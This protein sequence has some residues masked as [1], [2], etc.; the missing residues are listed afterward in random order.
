MNRIYTKNEWFKDKNNRTVI[1]RGVNL[2]GDCKNPYPDGG[3]YIQTDFSNH[4]DVSFV[5]R[6]FPLKDADEHFTRLKSW[7]FN[8]LR[9]L[10][11]WEAIEHSGP[12]K[13]D[14]NYLEYYAK[15]CK[16]AG[17]YGFYIFVDFHQ[18]AWSRMTGGDGAP[19]WLFEKVGIDYTKISKADAALVMQHSYNFNDPRPVQDDNYPMM[20]WHQNYDYPANCIM[21]TLFF[22]GADFAP[23]LI[24][25]GKNIQN[26]MQDHYFS[27]LLE[28]AKRVKDMSHVIGFDTLNEP[29]PGWIGK[30][31]KKGKVMKGVVW[32]PIAGL[33]SSHGFSIDLPVKGLIKKTGK[34]RINP[35]KISIWF[36]KTDPF[37]EAGAWKLKNGGFYQILRNDF[38]QKVNGKKINFNNDYIAP[39]FHNVANNIRSI[40][41]DW[42]LFAEKDASNIIHDFPE[43]MPK[44]VVNSSHWYDFF[45]NESKKF[46][47]LLAFYKFQFKLIKNKSKKIHNGC[48]TI[49]GEFGMPFDLDEGNSYKQ[50]AKGNISSEI[51]KSHIIALDLMYNSIDS[52]MLSSTQWNYT[53]NN[54][55][56]LC[57]GDGWNQ[58]DFSI[59][60]KDQ[61][62]N[63]NDI[64]SGGRALSGFVRPYPRFI[65]GKP[66]KV[67]FN[68]KKGIFKLKFQSDPLINSPT[69]IYIPKI[70]YPNGYEIF[71][72]NVKIE[73][74]EKDQTL[75]LKNDTKS[76]V[77]VTIM[78]K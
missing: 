20:C 22:G 17:E 27:C 29:F 30:P 58:E 62:I 46:N 52:L 1:L 32:S 55:N 6:P 76:E 33:Y 39:F 73:R 23:S 4:R 16:I 42:I 41:Q 71:A 15:L 45:M 69:E 72:D 54:S 38:F 56:N 5:N 37:Q 10:T 59:F 3:T 68:R 13:F 60:S 53:A 44:N 24:I 40:N 50:F 57:I 67:K 74:N 26:Y 19:C 78:R 64:N 77:N 2:G 11:T 65:Q 18:D 36:G 25:E 51:W 21:W 12:G 9:L 49:I 8:C 43:N 48:P 34:K 35:N 31:M 61:I 75:L 63:P 28:V 7:G 66:K 14:K 70:Q 47:R